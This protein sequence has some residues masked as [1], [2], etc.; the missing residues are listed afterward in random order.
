MA[1]VSSESYWFFKKILLGGVGIA[2][3]LVTRDPDRKLKLD[4]VRREDLLYFLNE[5][6]IFH[7]LKQSIILIKNVY[8]N[9][10]PRYDRHFY[11]NNEALEICH[12]VD[13]DLRPFICVFRL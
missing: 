7:S 3:G 6:V 12:H 1:A 11:H 10:V 2:A 13:I 4:I 5:T 9:I 8:E